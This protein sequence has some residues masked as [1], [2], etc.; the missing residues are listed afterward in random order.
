MG[1]PGKQRLLARKRHYGFGGRVRCPAQ[2]ASRRRRTENYLRSVQIPQRPG[3]DD[4]SRNYPAAEG[5]GDRR[6]S[7]RN[8]N[9]NKPSVECGKGEGRWWQADVPCRTRIERQL[10]RW[11]CE[12]PRS[13][14]FSAR[15]R[16]S[17]TF[18]STSLT[19]NS[20]ASSVQVVAAK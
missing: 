19:A 20:S 10:Q 16:P 1:L 2:G 15:L 8:N 18:P 17:K 6:Q 14:K 12:W 3:R 13:A 4:R 9:N 7:V 11:H 5:I